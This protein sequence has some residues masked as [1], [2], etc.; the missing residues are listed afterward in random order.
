MFLNGAEII[1]FGGGKSVSQL[2]RVKRVQGVI[3]RIKEKGVTQLYFP[4]PGLQWP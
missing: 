1:R 2:D 3:V 4:T